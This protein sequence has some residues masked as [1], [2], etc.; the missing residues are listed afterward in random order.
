MARSFQAQ[1]SVCIFCLI[2]ISYIYTHTHNIHT[3]IHIVHRI[4]TPPNVSNNSQKYLK[5]YELFV[6]LSPTCIKYVFAVAGI[7]V[8]LY[9]YIYIYIY[10]YV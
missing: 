4:S 3:Y 8:H 10:I 9:I 2:Y 6:V 7:N 1:K 5:I